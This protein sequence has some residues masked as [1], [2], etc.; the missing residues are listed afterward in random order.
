MSTS[1]ADSRPPTEQSNT[2]PGA[3]SILVVSIIGSLGVV[4][5]RMTVP[6]DHVSSDWVKP[7]PPERLRGNHPWHPD[8]EDVAIIGG[9]LFVFVRDAG[10]ISID[11]R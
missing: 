6:R 8:I 5:L 3:V 9:R 2:N 11:R 4:V 10:P 1:G 7:A